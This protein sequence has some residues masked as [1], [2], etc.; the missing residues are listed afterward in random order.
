MSETP[1]PG[2]PEPLNSTPGGPA[3][4]PGGPKGRLTSWIIIAVVIVG[5]LIYISAHRKAAAAAAAATGATPAAGHFMVANQVQGLVAPNFTLTRLDGQPIS[6]AQFKGRPVVLDF[7]A[8]WCGPCKEEIPS[9]N[10]L[11]KKYAAQGLQ[12]IGI[13]EDNEAAPVKAYLAGHH[14]DY[15]VAMDLGGLASTWGMPFGLPTTFFINREG[16]I[17]ARVEGLEGRDELQY[18]IQQIL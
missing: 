8:S 9:W 3:P 14:L 15:P 18:R 12:I 7:W 5:G 1:D 10:A 2:T 17:S 16:K 6:L 13:A 11:Q 4:A